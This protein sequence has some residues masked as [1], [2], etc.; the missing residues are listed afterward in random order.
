[1]SPFRLCIWQRVNANSCFFSSSDPGKGH[2][3]DIGFI[4]L[5]PNGKRDEHVCVEKRVW[6][7]RSLLIQ[8]GTWRGG[9]LYGRVQCSSRDPPLHLYFPSDD[10]EDCRGKGRGPVPSVISVHPEVIPL[11]TKPKLIQLLLGGSWF[12]LSLSGAGADCLTSNLLR[13]LYLAFCFFSRPHVR[14]D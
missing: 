13:F 14:V 7:Y 8:I 4:N 2:C 5:N 12:V 11:H 3:T 6:F 9:G 10:E 1:M